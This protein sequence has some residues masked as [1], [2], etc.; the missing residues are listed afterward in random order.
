MQSLSYK[1][2]FSQ[3][4]YSGARE[5]VL[6]LRSQSGFKISLNESFTD[7][8]SSAGSDVA[9]ITTTATLS[10]SEY[11]INGTKKWIT[12]GM[13]ADYASMTVRTGGENAGGKGISLILVPLKDHPGVTRRRLKVAGQIVAGTSFIELD[14]VRVPRENLIGRENEGMKYIMHNFNHERMFI[15]VGVTRQ[16]RVALSSAFAYCLQRKAFNKVGSE[17]GVDVI[18]S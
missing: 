11:I 3:I 17:Y 14:D 18:H 7:L 4:S 12:N 8:I 1:K 10:G 13:M 9:S 2:D 5:S 6:L 16:A 15:S